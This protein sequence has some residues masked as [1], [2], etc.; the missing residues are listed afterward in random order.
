MPKVLEEM[1]HGGMTMMLVTHQIGFA[2]RVAHRVVFLHEGRVWEE[3]PAA[4]ILAEPRTSELEAFLGAV[5][6]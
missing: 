4:A 2:R 5:L 1:A 6:H 3:G